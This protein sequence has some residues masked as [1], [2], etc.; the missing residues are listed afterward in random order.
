MEA[1]WVGV[2]RVVL[3]IPGARSLKDGR[4]VVRSLADRA[5]HRFSVSVNEVESGEALQRRTLVFTTAGNDQRTI[6]TLLDQVRSFVE[7]N[8]D[9]IAGTVDLDVF[10]WHPPG[11]EI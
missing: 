5:R 11:M 7:S 8:P 9:A 6:R 3:A 10:R 4:A 1:V 2:L